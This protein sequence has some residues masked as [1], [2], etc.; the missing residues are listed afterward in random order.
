MLPIIKLS[1]L[2]TNPLILQQ[3]TTL[4]TLEKGILVYLN[5]MQAKDA[6]LEETTTKYF[7]TNAD[8]QSLAIL[9]FYILSSLKVFMFSNE[10]FN[11]PSI[12]L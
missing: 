8:N 7:S 4:P 12:K 1:Y 2:M 3:A 10:N 9:S 11:F 5:S 6:L